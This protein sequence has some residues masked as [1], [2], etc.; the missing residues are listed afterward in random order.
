M[1]HVCRSSIFLV[2]VVGRVVLCTWKHLRLY[3]PCSALVFWHFP[4]W[5]VDKLQFFSPVWMEYL[6]KTVLSDFVSLWKF[7]KIMKWTRLHCITD[8]TKQT[9]KI[10]CNK[11]T[12][13]KL[14]CQVNMYGYSFW[15]LM[16]CETQKSWFDQFCLTF[17]DLIHFEKHNKEQ[18]SESDMF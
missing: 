4:F 18:A 6:L 11:S 1:C 16:F 5:G 17:W 2:I 15:G 7:G 10:Y 3:K 8:I 14:R 9:D 13:Y 12:L